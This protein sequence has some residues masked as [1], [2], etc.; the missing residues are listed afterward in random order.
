MKRGCALVAAYSSGAAADFH[1]LP[2][3]SNDH[4]TP[5]II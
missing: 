2:G 1:R 3:R 4:R 5:R